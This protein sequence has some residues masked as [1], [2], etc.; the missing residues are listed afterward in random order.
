M[1]RLTEIC[2]GVRKLL[3][4]GM[5]EIPEFSL[6][7]R[8]A[9]GYLETL[10][11]NGQRIPLFSSRYERRIRAIA[12]YGNSAEDNSALNVYCFVGCDIPLDRL[13]YFELDIAEYV[14][15]SRIKKITAIVNGGAANIIAV[16]ENGTCA[17]MDLGN[18]MASGAHYQCQHRLITKHGMA[19]DLSAADMTIQHQLY[20][21]GQEGNAVYDDDEAYLFGLD[22]DQ[23]SKALTIHGIL[24][25]QQSVEGWAE[26]DVRYRKMVKAVHESNELGKPIY[27]D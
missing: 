22:E 15:H 16:M 14:L 7:P 4:L 25:G 23:V 27:V 18:T 12:K 2:E 8:E 6:E 19:N 11:W 13:I 21:F 26:N 1:K 3:S 24:T 5:R 20:L 10:V 17:N 9:D